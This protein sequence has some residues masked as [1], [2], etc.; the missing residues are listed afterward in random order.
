VDVRD[1]SG[2]TALVTGAASGIGRAT[3]L[4]CARRGADLAICDVDDAGLAA[5]EGEI[6]GLGRGVLARRIDVA[7]REEVRDWAGEVHA[8]VEAVDLL[9]NNAGVGLGA[10]FLDTSLEDWEWIARINLFGVI[11]GCHFFVPAMVRRGAGGHVV[12]VASAAAYAPLPAQSAYAAT[13]F[14]V[15]GLS[16]SLRAELAAQGIG[17]T[18]ACPG[19]IDTAIVETSRLKGRVATP[20]NRRRTLVFYRRRGYR[21]ERVAANILKAVGRQRAVAPISAEAW[22]MYYGMRLAPGLFRW[23]NRKLAERV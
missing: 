1:L 11:H 23:T 7:N 13:K 10:L 16:E 5:V 14:A 22:L 19:F 17:V 3:A 9:V 8:R 15:L 4:A 6:R 2:R 20:E 18:A 12:N 21:P